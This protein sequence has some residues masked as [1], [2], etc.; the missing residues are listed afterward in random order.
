M[1]ADPRALST[2]L[3]DSLVRHAPTVLFINNAI[4]STEIASSLF[5]MVL[6]HRL[7]TD[8]RYQRMLEHMVVLITPWLRSGSSV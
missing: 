2:A 4:H 7:A 8:E 5:S 1:L 3:E 6:A